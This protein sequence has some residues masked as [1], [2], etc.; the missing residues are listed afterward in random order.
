MTPPN[1]RLSKRPTQI[2][3]G[4]DLS[5]Q[6][7][8]VIDRALQLARSDAVLHVAHVVAETIPAIEMDLPYPRRASHLTEVEQ[9]L[10]REVQKRLAATAIQLNAPP[11]LHVLTGNVADALIDLVTRL[12]A[13]LV[14]VGTHGRRGIQRLLLGSVAERLV[15]AAPCAVVIVRQSEV[16]VPKLTPACPLCVETRRSS[17]GR[18][19]WC[20][21]HRVNLGRRHT[22]HL[23]HRNVAARENM[24]LLIAP[25]PTAAPLRH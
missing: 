19:L 11:V 12:D 17:G 3:T 20:N 23:V 6:S 24:P 25:G 5:R 8:G 14:V 16:T 2:V 18:E 4:V 10:G 22:Y 13:E 1:A 15:K 21:Q 7:A 9:E